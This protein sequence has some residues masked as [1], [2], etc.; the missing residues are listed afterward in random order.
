[1]DMAMRSFIVAGVLAL[2]LILAGL[3]WWAV[4]TF[5][6]GEEDS[7]FGQ[8]LSYDDREGD[9]YDEFGGWSSQNSRISITSGEDAAG[10]SDVFERRGERDARPTV[11]GSG[12]QFDWSGSGAAGSASSDYA[13]MPR[14]TSAD[15]VEADCRRR[16]GGSY[17]C[18]CLVRLA[19]T[20]L[21]EAEFDFL[22]LAEELE[23]RAERLARA[24]LDPRDLAPMAA[25]L[26]ALDA[27]SQRRCGA[28]LMR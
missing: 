19:R 18:R 28:G 10:S 15:R 17:A 25:K 11:F 5:T 24:G 9:L 26:I 7:P 1:M 13:E 22:S 8:T 16:G 14:D 3:A 21:T 27:G 6:G 20:D 12:P 23:P 2:V 4:A